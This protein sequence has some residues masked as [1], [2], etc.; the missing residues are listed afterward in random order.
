MHLC[1]KDTPNKCKSICNEEQN[2]YESYILKCIRYDDSAKY[3]HC[4][5]QYYE[6]R[7]KCRKCVNKIFKITQNYET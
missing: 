7:D 3:W 1:N 6:A 4:M 5:N 2:F